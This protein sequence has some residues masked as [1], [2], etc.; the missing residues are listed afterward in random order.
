MFQDLLAEEFGRGQR[1]H[2]FPESAIYH[3]S[4]QQLT[5]LEEHYKLMM[6]W[7]QRLNLTRI[8]GLEEAVQLHYC[9][10]LFFGTLLP[11]VALNIA[12]VG[13]GAG[14]PGIP[15][16]ILRPECAFTLI[17]SHQRKAVFLRE[18]SSGLKN[19]SVIAKRAQDVKQRFDWSVSRAV[20]PQEA[21]GLSLG[22]SIALLIG[23]EDA[24]RLEDTWK[25]IPLPWG[26]GRVAAIRETK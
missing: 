24:S 22:Q 17:E 7:N 1:L 21:I 6:R 15:L 8:S 26:K 19:V 23:K 16:A 20:S 14:F 11:T 25:I 2:E 4:G 10:S 18:A 13:S 12:D 3:L 5:L 9:E